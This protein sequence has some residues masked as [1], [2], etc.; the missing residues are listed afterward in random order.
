V[1]P[2]EIFW[3]G[4]PRDG[5]PAINEPK[6]VA[7]MD[8]KFLRQWDRVLGVFHNGFAKAFPIKKIWRS[9]M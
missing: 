2:G 4:V 6:F 9:I 3:G 5:I 1:P 8:A 7:P